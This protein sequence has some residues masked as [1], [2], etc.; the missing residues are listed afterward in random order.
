MR[1]KAARD[2]ALTLRTRLFQDTNHSGNDASLTPAA[3]ARPYSLLLK[4]GFGGSRCEGLLNREELVC[5]SVR[6]SVLQRLAEKP[7]RLRETS[8]SERASLGTKQK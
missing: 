5:V 3:A 4:V 8:A 6:F 1:S 7:Q 2:E